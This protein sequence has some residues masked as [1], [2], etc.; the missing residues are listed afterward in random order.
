MQA[1]YWQ[2]GT[3]ISKS[4]KLFETL[5]TFLASGQGASNEPA[6]ELQ[7]R[8]KLSSDQPNSFPLGAELFNLITILGVASPSITENISKNLLS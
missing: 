8:L 5:M 2:G 4:L 3:G 7:K 1:K 6:F